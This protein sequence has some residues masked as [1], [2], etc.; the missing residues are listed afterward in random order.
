MK[1]RKTVL[2]FFYFVVG[3]AWSQTFAQDAST[4]GKEF[5]VSFI[6]NGYKYHPDVSSD[7]WLRVQLLVSAQRDCEGDIINPNTGWTRHFS[8]EANNIFSID[9][10][11]E[12]CYIET[13]DYETVVNKG[14]Q[15]I[16]TDT[17]SVYCANIATY[18]FDASFV[19]PVQGLA[20]DYIIQTHEQSGGNS[21]CP[22][23]A[24][25]IVA[26]EDN[27]T[28][29]I[30]PS[31]NTLGDKWAGEE[32]SI[33]LNKGQAYQVRSNQSLFDSRDLSG[34][35]VTARDCKKIAVFNGNNL[36]LVP[37]DAFTDSDCIFEQAMPLHSWGRK[38]AVTSSCNRDED[39]IKITS[40]T[41]ENQIRRNGLPICTLD[42]NESYTFK[43]ESYDKSCYIEASHSCAVYLYNSSSNGHGFGAPSMVWISPI[44]QRIDAITFATFNYN[45]TNVNIGQHYVNIIVESQDI[46]SVML[47][48]ELLNA[49]QFEPI[50]GNPDYQFITKEISHGVHHLSCPNG[51]NAHVY[52]FGE[53]RGYAY[54]V[55]SKAADLSTIITI[56]D[57]VIKPNDTIVNCDL[58]DIHFQAE[59]NYSDYDMLWDFGDGETSTEFD[60]HHT[61]S[62]QGIYM[63]ALTVTTPENPCTG[64]STLTS[65]FYIDNRKADDQYFTDQIC[66]SGPGSYMENGFHIDY[67]TSGEYEDSYTI[68][69]ENGCE[70]IATLH[71]IVTDLVEEEVEIETGHCDQFEWRGKTYYESGQYADTALNAMGCYSVYHLDLDLDFTPNPTE[72][73][74]SDP[75]NTVP[76]WVVTATEFQINDYD[77]TLS[78]LN[79]NCEWDTVLW[80]IENEEVRWVLESSGPIGENCKLY[81]LARVDDT[82][83][84]NAQVF[85]ECHPEG[86]ERRFWLV[87]SFYGIDDNNTSAASNPFDFNVVPNPNQGQMQLVFEHLTG[88][89]DV[90]VFDMK[91][92]LIDNFQTYSNSSKQSIPYVMKTQSDGLYLFIVS[93]K[94]GI[95]TKKIVISDSM[96]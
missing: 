95:L 74:P 24:F 92:S 65:V 51:F 58:S 38:F 68:T 5:W 90:K 87:S 30:T 39:Y 57:L 9:L 54:M 22:T 1:H 53:A 81:V 80:S 63:G 45:H 35:R 8:V 47:D 21:Y 4:Q 49:S 61:Y 33:T 86:V 70:S 16:T 94:E 2:L 17:V 88:K 62:E 44:E 14:L 31:V 77:F 37:A 29:D 66:F 13:S 75:A 72:I 34:S 43:L 12:Q 10:E 79:P 91:G 41:D 85:N 6:G 76:H 73:Y 64:S 93:S 25:V 60:T 89:I 19:L 42:A 27:T 28:I 40:S 18:S 71:L 23:S 59:I 69:A 46:E 36:T 56:D 84:L 50:A 78:D 32:Y 55:G 26:T 83:W 67:E 52:G 3:L 11:E 48:G 7:G 82:V 96:Y 20:D 15:I